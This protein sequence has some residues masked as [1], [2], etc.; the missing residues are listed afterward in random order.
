VKVN[1][2]MVGFWR[3]RGMGAEEKR[4]VVRV[5]RRVCGMWKE[6]GCGAGLDA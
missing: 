5:V 2:G 1:N 4:V 6:S 3:R